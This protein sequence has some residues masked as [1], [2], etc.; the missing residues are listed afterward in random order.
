[1]SFLD[2]LR[3]G[4]TSGPP[5]VELG[6]SRTDRWWTPLAD[7]GEKE[8]LLR[9]QR[10]EVLAGP[11]AVLPPLERAA[12]LVEE[13]LCLLRPGEDGRF[14]LVAGCLCA[15]S[16]WRL[17]E[18]LGKSIA[19]VHGPVAHYEED[20]AAKVDHFLSRLR[21]GVVVA[22]RNWMV[23]E[24]SVRFEPVCPPLLRVE[25]PDQWLRSERQTL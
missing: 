12:L 8:R 19:A 9:E 5:W 21:P 1:M 23:H 22:R 7:R 16:H 25:P 2:E 11:S 14:V 4:T 18:K 24:T 10:A 6:T 17:T 15:P 3:F 20:L 13:D